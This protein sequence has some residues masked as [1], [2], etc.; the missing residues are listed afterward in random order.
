LITLALTARELAVAVHPVLLA[1][2]EA[3]LILARVL[4]VDIRRVLIDAVPSWLRL[5]RIVINSITSLIPR[6]RK[7]ALLN[8][9]VDDIRGEHGDGLAQNILQHTATARAVVNRRL[10]S[11]K[12]IHGLAAALASISDT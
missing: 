8:S 12:L 4:G 10:L 3:C 7:A 1:F 6:N 2:S 9:L 11:Q 5:I